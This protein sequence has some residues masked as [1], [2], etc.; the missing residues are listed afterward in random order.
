[1][2]KLITLGAVLVALTACQDPNDKSVVQSTSNPVYE[3]RKLFTKDGC[4]AY[5]FADDGRYRYYVVC[6]EG[7]RVTTSDHFTTGS[8]PIVT[9]TQEI[10]T[11]MR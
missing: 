2:L 7:Q 1:M 9:H 3:V 5:R 4:T 8:K 10:S 11:V 6:E